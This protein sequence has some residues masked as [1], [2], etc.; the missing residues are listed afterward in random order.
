MCKFQASRRTSLHVSN[1]QDSRLTNPGIAE[2]VVRVVSS[3]A[4]RSIAYRWAA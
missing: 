1:S 2:E 4:G 3:S